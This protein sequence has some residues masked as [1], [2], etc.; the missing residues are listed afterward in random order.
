MPLFLCFVDYKKAF[1]SVPHSQLS[2]V[3]LEMGFPGHIV[4]LISHL[5]RKQEAVVRV[6]NGEKAWLRIRR[7]V[8][9]GCIISPYLFN[10]YSEQVMRVALDGYTKGF[11]IGGRLINNLRYADDVVLI[12]MSEAELQELIDR[13][14]IASETVGLTIN[15]AKN[16]GHGF[17]QGELGD[18]SIQKWAEVGASSVFCVSGINIP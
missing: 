9:Q 12:A 3:M 13:V 11:Q 17:I 18:F 5:Y 1:D 6:E 14:T 16:K 2:R 10:I 7:G 8:C 15:T 4:Q